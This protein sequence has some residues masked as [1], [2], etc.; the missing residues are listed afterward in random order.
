VLQDGVVAREQLWVTGKLWNT[1]HA[2]D[3]VAP[4]IVKTLSDLK[5]RARG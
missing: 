2:P 3:R 4:A 1:E 5:V